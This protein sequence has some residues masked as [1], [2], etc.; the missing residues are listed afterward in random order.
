M[1]LLKL[2]GSHRRNT[3]VWDY[4]FGPSQK[5]KLRLISFAERRVAWAKSGKAD[6]G[7]AGLLVGT[8]AVEWL[9]GIATLLTRRLLCSRPAHSTGPAIHASANIC[10]RWCQV[11]HWMLD[12][13]KADV[14]K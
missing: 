13:N 5:R 3:V 14:E 10:F 1:V 4:P 12:P 2:L 7:L 6:E 11:S 9:S 8:V